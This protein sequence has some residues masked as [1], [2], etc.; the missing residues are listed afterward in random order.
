MAVLDAL[1]P[2]KL[3]VGEECIGSVLRELCT[4]ARAEELHAPCA[5]LA[6]VLNAL[7]KHVRL[8][9]DLDPGKARRALWRLQ[10]LQQVLVLHG[11]EELA[12]EALDKA[13][14]YGI[15]FH[16]ALYVALAEQLGQTLYTLSTPSLREGSGGRRCWAR[17]VVPR[18]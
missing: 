5:V 11:V 16:D 2:V 8:L 12:G 3:V 6:E 4:A 13:L 15:A 10:R 18:C 9:R 1:F 7:W 14:R 17:V